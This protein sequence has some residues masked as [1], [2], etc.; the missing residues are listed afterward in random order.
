V[1]TFEI[2]S[3]LEFEGVPVAFVKDP[4]MVTFDVEKEKIVGL[5]LAAPPRRGAKKS[6]R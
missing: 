6:A 3:E 5:K 1:G 2:G 4:F